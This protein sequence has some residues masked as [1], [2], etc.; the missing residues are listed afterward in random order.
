MTRR[1]YDLMATRPVLGGLLLV[2]AGAEIIWLD[3]GSIGVVLSGASG[4]TPILLGASLV[5]FGAL[6]WVAPL[7]APML[8]LLA[9]AAAI[10]AFVVANLGGYVIGSLLGVVGGALVFAW[11]AHPQPM[12][13][14]EA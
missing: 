9:Q 14:V 2:L 10:V 1:L 3:G 4:S 8:G 7:Y 5:M 11:R 6:A 12:S 13:E